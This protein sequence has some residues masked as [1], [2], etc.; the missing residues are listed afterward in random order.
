MIFFLLTNFYFINIFYDILMKIAEEK[1]NFMAEKK[2]F[3]LNN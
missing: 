1:R 2:T 3:A